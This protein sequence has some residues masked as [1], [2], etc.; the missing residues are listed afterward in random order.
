MAS[1]LVPLS[2]RAAEDGGII[3]VK[4]SFLN[5]LQKRDS[6]LIGDQL[7]YGFLLENVAEGTALAFPDYSEKFMDSVEVVRSWQIDTVKTAKA[8][9]KEK[10]RLFDIKAA[11]VLTSFDEGNYTLPEI[12]VQRTLPDG[13]VD[14]LLFDAQR[15]DVRTMPVDTTTYV[16]H[17]IKGQIGYPLTFKELLPYI[18]A[19]LLL[20]AIVYAILWYVR[21][22]KREEDPTFGEPAHISALRKL[23]KFRGSAY[24]AAEK[25]KA[26]YSGV[27]DAL[28]EYIVARYGVGAMEMTTAE[29]FAGLRKTDLP[30]ELFDEMKELFERADFVKYA[31]MTVPDEDNAKVI[32]SAVKFVTQTYQ[33]TLEEESASTAQPEEKPSVPVNKTEDETAYM[34]KN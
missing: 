10:R 34:P 2:L 14:T 5:Q 3:A 27:T 12:A 31:K 6:V 13:T 28:R 17:D 20:A 4:G 11:V 24:W 25:Q 9:G 16:P 30:K 18:G 21:K 15:L 8:K 33:E 26:F 19:V 1:V 23:D 29:I 32:P 22:R 7:D